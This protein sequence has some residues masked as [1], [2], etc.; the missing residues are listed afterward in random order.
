MKKL[1]TYYHA[2]DSD[3]CLIWHVY[4]YATEQIIDSF[5][6]EEDAEEF[7]DDLENGKG[8]HGFTPSF[9]LRKVFHNNINDAFSAEF[10]A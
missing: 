7:M 9:M 10:S 3:D 2:F 6:F 5:L 1:Y 4:E 8:F